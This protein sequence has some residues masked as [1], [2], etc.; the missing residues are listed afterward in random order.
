MRFGKP[1][2]ERNHA[3]LD[4]EAEEEEREQPVT[5]GPRHGV[6]R[7]DRR[8][9]HG[10]G[11][12]GQ[13]QESGDQAAGAD[14]RHDQIQIGG[15]AVGAHLVVGRHECRRHERE[16][17][18]RKQERDDGI[19]GEHDLQRAQQ[20][21]E[22]DAD[23]DRPPAEMRLPDVADA[24]YR[25]RNGQHRQ[26][27]KEPRRQPVYRVRE[28]EPGCLMNEPH[29][30][31]GRTG[32]QH[33]RGRQERRDGRDAGAEERHLPR[34]ACPSRGQQRQ[35]DHAD[36]EHER[37]GQAVRRTERRHPAASGPA[38]ISVLTAERPS[39]LRAGVLSASTGYRPDG[40]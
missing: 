16:Q 3:R 18:P 23:E 12:G 10:A 15:A 32:A 11:R 24:E 31:Y 37:H 22:P 39:A 33:L 14:V 38:A 7:Q 27:R 36:P 30:V 1:H 8:E 2:V 20:Y 19:G 29:A 6:T 5:Q 26:D 9:R 28:R 25:G 4:A 34:H 13:S 40:C 35:Y 17:L 21:V